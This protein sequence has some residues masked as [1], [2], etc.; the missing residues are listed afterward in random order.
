MR[1]TDPIGSP[2]GNHLH[3]IAGFWWSH[4]HN[5]FHHYLLLSL[6]TLWMFEFLRH[7]SESRIP[8]VSTVPIRNPLVVVDNH[9]YYMVGFWLSPLHN[10]FRHILPVA[11]LTLWRSEFLRHMSLSKIP[12]MS[13]VTTRS[14]LCSHWYYTGDLWLSLPRSWL[15]HFVLLQGSLD[16]MFEIPHHMLLCKIPSLSTGSICS[17][18]SV[19]MGVF[20]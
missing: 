12:T 2:L 19:E 17:Q 11:R 16:M 1:S 4:L 8:M 20:W 7:R 10:F 15:L 18:L 3:C 9:L 13:S 6:L 14:P 5:L